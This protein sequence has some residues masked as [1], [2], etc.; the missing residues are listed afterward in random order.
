MKLKDLDIIFEKGIN[1]KK[2]QKGEISFIPSGAVFPNNIKKDKCFKISGDTKFPKT[3]LLINNDILFNSGGV[4]TLGR[5]GFFN[6]HT[7]T[8]PAVCDP[9][10][11]IIRNSDPKLYSKYLFYFFQSNRTKKNIIKYT[12][13]STGITSIRKNDLLNFGI[14]LPSVEKQ[15]QIVDTLDFANTIRHKRKEQLMF[16][17][18]Y[19]KSIFV[20]TFGDPVENNK[21]WDMCKVI[22]VCKCIVPA[23]DKP[24]SFSG[25]V[26]WITTDDL[27]HLRWTQTSKKNIGLNLDEITTVK[28]RIIPKNS[29]VMTCVGDLGV[30]SIAKNEFVMNQQLHAF[31][32]TEQIN[33]VF[34]TY[35]LSFQKDYMLRMA[36][37][38]TVPYMNKTICNSVP[39]LLPPIELQNKFATIVKRVEDTKQKMQ[40]SLAE[41]DNHFNALSQKY[42]G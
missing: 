21:N 7:W 11:F 20:E 22:D 1:C 31:I 37:T 14:N 26:P 30:V 35:N 16:F 9:F 3:K 25:D 41:M 13:G 33:N 6:K 32:C 24:K 4:G 27:E 19:L 40:E 8:G 29:V 38:T 15:K 10:V 39:I 17:D 36:S 23:R 2:S 18:V 42:F 34:L 12:V 5:V 28:A